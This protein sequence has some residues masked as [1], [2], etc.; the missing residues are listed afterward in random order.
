LFIKADNNVTIDVSNNNVL[1]LVLHMLSVYF[2]IA[3]TIPEL[4]K[5]LLITKIAATVMTTGLAKPE[6]AVSAG[7]ILNRVSTTKAESEIKSYLNFPNESK[8]KVTPKVT[9]TII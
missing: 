5:P 3:S 9:K 6:N 7:I 8:N 2:V 4:I 1:V